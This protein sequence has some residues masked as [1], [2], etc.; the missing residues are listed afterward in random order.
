MTSFWWRRGLLLVVASLAAVLA[1]CGSGT[2]YN[3]FKPTRFVAFGDGFSDLGQTGATYSVNDGSAS[4]WSQRIA[5]GYGYNLTAQSA[6]GLGYAQGNARVTQTPDAAGVSSTLTVQQQIDS[7]LASNTF[8]AGDMVIINGGISDMVVQGQALLA[9]TITPAQYLANAAQAGVDLATQVRRLVN[10]GATHVVVSG[11]YDMSKTPW[12][13][14][15]GQAT[16]MSNASIQFNTSLLTSIVD[17]G[18]FVQYLDAAYFVNLMANQPGTY[19]MVNSIAPA[20]TSVDPGAGIGIGLNQINSY[21]CT[22]STI[23]SGVTY[24]QYLWADNV[25]MT[26]QAHVFFANYS[27]AKLTLRW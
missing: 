2:V 26:P 4:I 15:S 24:N 17:L 13:T 21:L 23:A 12:G 18:G 5:A 7:F 22:P 16:A 11:V 8:N 3:A 25:Y 20:C 10:A 27:I 9:G 1:G 14:N 6:G 19:S